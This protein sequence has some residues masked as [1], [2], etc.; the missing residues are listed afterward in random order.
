MQT[1]DISP[2]V[3]VLIAGRNRPM[4]W[5]AIIGELVDNAIDTGAKQKERRCQR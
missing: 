4:T 5:K 3:E 1:V 2:G